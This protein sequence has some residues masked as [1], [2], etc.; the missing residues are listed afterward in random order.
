MENTYMFIPVQPQ[1]NTRTLIVYI[2][3][4]K[5]I[6]LHNYECYYMENMCIAH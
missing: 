4:L 5:K 6:H 3:G 2:S 1:E